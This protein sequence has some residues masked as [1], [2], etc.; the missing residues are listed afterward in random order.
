[1]AEKRDYYEVLGVDK[2]ASLD[3]IKKAYRK[4]AI[5]YHPDKNQGKTEEEKKI[6][7]EKFKEV[8]E[9]YEVL[10][11]DNR[12][13]EYNQFGFGG[14]TGGGFNMDMEEIIRRMQ[15]MHGFGGN[16]FGGRVNQV[17]QGTDIR[18]PLEITLENVYSGV[19]KTG[20]Y[21]RKVTCPD[22]NGVGVIN[23][24][25]IKVCPH[26]QGSGMYREVSR[27]GNM[28]FQTET[29]CPH[30]QGKGKIITN[31][32]HTCHGEGLITIDESVEIDVPKGVEDNMSIAFRGLGNM[33]QGDGIAGNLIIV[34]RIKPHDFFDK[35]GSS[36]FI[37]KEVSILDCILGVN[38]TVLAIDGNLY[39][40]KIR[41]GT[42]NGEH[43]RIAGKGLPIIN[44]DKRGDL[45]VMIKQVLPTHL[46]QEEIELLNKLKEMPH[47]RSEDLN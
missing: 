38:S 26:C 44:S 15:A 20:K 41:Q 7:E 27:Q 5:E 13:A 14:S 8:A 12:R 16:P 35:K 36:T 45:I 23:G 32:C 19:H 21:K 17:R 37:M 24:S 22:C 11:D 46:N 18:I 31:P 28:V 2:T 34:I 39:K 1:M 33:P 42:T 47:F 10:S 4:L 30:C 3:E 6:S 43:Y 9:A 29:I 25:D 40:F